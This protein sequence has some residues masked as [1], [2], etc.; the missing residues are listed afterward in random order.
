M[1]TQW[2]TENTV[3]NF[4]TQWETENTVGNWKHNEKLKKLWETGNTVR[5]WKH[6]QKLKLPRVWK[7]TAEFETII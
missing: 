7:H 2:E 6:S 5:N 4:E 3:R 1:K